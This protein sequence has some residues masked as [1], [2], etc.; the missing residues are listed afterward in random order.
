MRG[1]AQLLG[2]DWRGR[3]WGAGG[4]SLAPTTPWPPAAQGGTPTVCCL[5]PSQAVGTTACTPCF[6]VWAPGLLAVQSTR[7]WPHSGLAV[8][9]M[10]VSP[11]GPRG[12]P[13]ARM[14]GRPWTPDYVYFENSSSNPYLIRRIEEL[15]KTASGNV[16]AKVVCFYRRRDISS[17]LIALADKHATLSVCYKTGSG[18]DASEEGE[19]EEEMENPEMVDLPE[20]LKHQLR[21]R[22]LFLSRQLE[23]LPATHIRGKCSVTLLNE[24]ESLKSYLEREQAGAHPAVLAAV[25]RPHCADPALLAG[26]LEASE[27]VKRVVSAARARGP[28]SSHRWTGLAVMPK[29]LTLWPLSLPP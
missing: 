29:L 14:E 13:G 21:H 24:T 22:E 28:T 9:Q 6:D 23:S 4:P 1:G 15:N 25:S 12:A 20:K 19:I 10:P 26:Q 17:S 18:A 7:A 8:P 2:G 16:E 3:Q 27:F 11:A 5:C